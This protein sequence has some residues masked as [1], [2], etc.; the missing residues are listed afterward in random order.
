MFLCFMF[1]LFM[2]LSDLSQLSQDLIIATLSIA[3]L[4][5]PLKK[6]LITMICIDV[7]W[8]GGGD[9]PVNET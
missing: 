6:S 3:L 2:Y 1:H 5:K 8:L 7:L 9:F 4:T